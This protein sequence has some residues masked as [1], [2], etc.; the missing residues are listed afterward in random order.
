MRFLGVILLSLVPLL[1]FMMKAAA[2]ERK[3]ACAA[4]AVELINGVKHAVRYSRTPIEA[5]LTRLS[6]DKRLSALFKGGASPEAV[7]AAVG[8]SVSQ[9]AGEVVA[10]CF[11]GAAQS[12]G[13][14]ALEKLSRTVSALK[15]E[16]DIIEAECSKRRPMYIKLG[17]LA[18]AFTA[19]ILI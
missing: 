11:E 8:E 7:A 9:R 13:V 12:D 19:V 5:A 14:G 6:E 16:L 3:R 15:R 2:I 4:A 10:D 17:V 1:V 18:A